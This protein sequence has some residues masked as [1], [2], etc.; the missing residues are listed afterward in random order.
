M[1]NKLKVKEVKQ[2]TNDTVSIA[3]EIPAD[4]K[5]GFNYQSGQYITIKHEV[6]GEDVR[7]AYS[8]CSSPDEEDFRIGVNHRSK[9]HG[10]RAETTKLW[11]EGCRVRFKE[12]SLFSGCKLPLGALPLDY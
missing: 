8:L 1:F 9:G 6:N 10:T 2:E 11:R 7:R 4:L 3:F 5:S 12:R